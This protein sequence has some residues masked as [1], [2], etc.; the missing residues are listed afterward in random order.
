MARVA[1]RVVF[2]RHLTGLR[3][4]DHDAP[5]LR[6]VGDDDLIVAR[7]ERNGRIAHVRCA[8]APDDLAAACDPRDP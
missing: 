6:E 2:P 3:I 8:Y 5:G 1:A 7:R 4:E